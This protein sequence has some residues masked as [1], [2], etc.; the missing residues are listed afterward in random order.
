MIKWFQGLQALP[1]FKTVVGEV[2]LLGADKKKEEKAKEEKP[3]EE[4]PKEEKKP[5][6]K[7]ADDETEEMDAAEEA[8][9]AEPKEKDPFQALPKGSVFP[10]FLL[11]HRIFRQ[12]TVCFV[13]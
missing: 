1:Q 2:K 8:L 3:K 12:L 9:A 4:K 7:E 13:G 5:K 10:P 11:V 6:K